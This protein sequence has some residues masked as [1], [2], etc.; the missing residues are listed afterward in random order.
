MHCATIASRVGGVPLLIEHGVY[1]LLFEAQNYQELAEHM[2][3]LATDES[4]RIR[5]GEALYERASTHFSIDATVARQR[6]IYSVLLRRAKRPK[7]KRDGILICGAY[8]KGNAGDDSIL[9]AILQQL[10]HIDPDL[11]LYV[12][13]RNPKQTQ[14][15]YRSHRTDLHNH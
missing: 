14:L 6:E 2:V 1:G 3:L 4:T 8:G 10:R 15:R 12:L 9:E 13:S 7:T 11:P 5:L